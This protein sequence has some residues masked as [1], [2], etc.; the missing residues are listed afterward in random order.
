M[1]DGR[2]GGRMAGSGEVGPKVEGRRPGGRAA[3]VV[4]AVRRATLELL[5]EVGYGRLQLPEVAVRA[6]VNKTTVYRRWPTKA[7]LVS[8]LLQA[9]AAEQ[10]P[11]RDTG[12]LIGDLIAHLEGLVA[13]LRT[14]TTRTVLKA[15]ISGEL[16]QS[17]A[18]VREAYF[19]ERFRLSA[20]IVDRAVGRGELPP[21]TDARLLIEDACSPVYF[22]LLIT[23][24]PITADD[25]ALFAARA[26]NS[27]R[28]TQ[29]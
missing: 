24:Q 16:D 8:E 13:I 29:Q 12:T 5:E 20:A 14:G 15:M 25:I 7:A 1:M 22:R 10:M 28:I 21:G 11:A 2:L 6:G 18:A 3:V 27:A 23:G 26:A 9:M 19:A 4:A 17:D